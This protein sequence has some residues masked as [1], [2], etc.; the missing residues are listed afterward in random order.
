MRSRVFPRGVTEDYEALTIDIVYGDS[1]RWSFLKSSVDNFKSTIASH[2]YLDK[3][4]QFVGEF[5][6]S[7]VDG[8]ER[9]PLPRLMAVDRLRSRGFSGQHLAEFVDR[10]LKTYNRFHGYFLRLPGLAGKVR[11]AIR[12]PGPGQPHARRKRAG[13]V[14]NFTLRK[15]RA[16]REWKT[17]VGTVVSRLTTVRR[18]GLRDT[19]YPVLSRSS[20]PTR[21]A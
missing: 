8:V 15:T 18:T 9:N 17:G 10:M 5:Y 2:A 1:R 3:G 7:I 4:A 14:K 20:R 11:P 12:V 19:G 21:H 6:I 16:S 13:N